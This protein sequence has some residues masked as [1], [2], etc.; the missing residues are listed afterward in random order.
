[1]KKSMAGSLVIF[2]RFP[3]EVLNPELGSGYM[4]G[5][6]ITTLIGPKAGAIARRMARA[7]KALYEKMRPP[8][9]L[10]ILNVSP[11]VSLQRKPDHQQDVVEAKSQLVGDLITLAESEPKRLRSIPL[12]ADLP[13]EDVF[14][15]LKK[16][17]W[18]IL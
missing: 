9:Y 16:R 2:D 18:E 4:D 6:K 11:E 8:E 5:S 17:I 15:Q 14:L 13:F 1:M 10:A 7:E 3:L 12:N